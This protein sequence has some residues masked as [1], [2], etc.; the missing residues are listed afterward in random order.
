MS[1]K[2]NRQSK[3][4][5]LADHTREGTLFR[6]PLSRLPLKET[7]WV[8]QTLPELLW[9]GLLQGKYGLGCGVDLSLA[10]AEAAAQASM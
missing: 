10:L 5:I 1:M 6:T 2:P 3:S 9:I 4:G 7:R 8:K